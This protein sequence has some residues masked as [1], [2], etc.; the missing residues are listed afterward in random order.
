MDEGM[1]QTMKW[2]RKLTYY[3]KKSVQSHMAN[4]SL[5]EI[6]N[7]REIERTRGKQIRNSPERHKLGEENCDSER[8]FLARFHRDDEYESRQ[9][10]E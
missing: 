9:Q 3:D 6:T 2:K 10:V 1:Y 7:F 8:D 5:A 4:G